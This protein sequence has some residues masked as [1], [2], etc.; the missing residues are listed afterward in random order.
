[1]PEPVVSIVTAAYD[2][3]L[4]LPETIESVRAQTFP[5]WEW[6]IVDDGSSDAT[7]HVAAATG[8]ERIRVERSAHSGLPAV[9][10]NRA[11][12]RTTG[13]YVAL[14]DADDVWYPRKLELQVAVL[15]SRPEVGLVH[16]PAD[17]LVRGERVP[18]ERL[19]PPSAADL[20]R[21]NSIFSS[22]VVVRRELLE[23]HGAFDPDPELWGSLDY[24]LWLRLLPHTQFAYVGE[25]LLA[26]RVHERQM[27]ARR[28]RME[29]GALRALEKARARPSPFDR[30]LTRSIGIQKAVLARP[31]RGRRELADAIRRDPRDLLAWKWLVRASAGRQRRTDS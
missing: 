12:E 3:E 24:E 18:A 21:E 9:G 30:E 2:A 31:G 8:D 10:R 28:G 19:A 22:S 23:R 15:E 25:P 16:A 27:S 11:I 17:R 20:V 7:A 13:R 14:L 6:V 5:D 26:Y 1:V 29:A 4:E